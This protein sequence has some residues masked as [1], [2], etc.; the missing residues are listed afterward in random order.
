MAWPRRLILRK[1]STNHRIPRRKRCFS[2]VSLPASFCFPFLFFSSYACMSCCA[3][4]DETAGDHKQLRP[5]V[6]QYSLRVENGRRYDM[7]VSLF[8]RLV[9]RG[10]PHTTVELQHRMPPEVRRAITPTIDVTCQNCCLDFSVLRFSCAV[11]PAVKTTGYA[12]WESQRKK[13]RRKVWP[14]RRR[15]VLS[16]SSA[17]LL[18]AGYYRRQETNHSATYGLL[19]FDGHKNIN[20]VG[21]MVNSELAQDPAPLTPRMR[22]CA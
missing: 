13:L 19:V 9:K 2:P 17:L 14:H 5:K 10:Y 15:S 3:Y 21:N 6:E 11:V 16:V 7:N 18:L 20:Q 22:S 1:I 12:L 4:D 8:E